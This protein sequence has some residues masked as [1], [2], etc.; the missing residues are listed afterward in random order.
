MKVNDFRS[1]FI[2]DGSKLSLENGVR[3]VRDTSVVSPVDTVVDLATVA[4]GAI[5]ASRFLIRDF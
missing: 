5:D 1:A 4:V 3:P 2:Q